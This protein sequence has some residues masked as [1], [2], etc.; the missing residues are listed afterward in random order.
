LHVRETTFL[1]RPG[2]AAHA[3]PRW[4]SGK[5]GERALR[6]IFFGGRFANGPKNAK[7]GDPENQF[8]TGSKFEKHRTKYPQFEPI[9]RFF[10]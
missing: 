10:S 2:R 1:E 6:Y 7:I 4:K 8:P 3:A 9:P 5:A